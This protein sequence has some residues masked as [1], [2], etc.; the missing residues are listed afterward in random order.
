MGTVASASRGHSSVCLECRA[1]KIEINR[2][3]LAIDDLSEAQS[4]VFNFFVF[5]WD[6]ISHLY[7]CTKNH[8]NI[9]LFL[10]FWSNLQNCKYKQDIQSHRKYLSH[11]TTPSTALDRPRRLYVWWGEWCEFHENDEVFWKCY[12]FLKMFGGSDTRDSQSK[13][14]KNTKSTKNSQSENPLTTFLFFRKC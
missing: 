4:I 10:T 1:S 3:M 9:E 8:E 12:A 11:K 14:N 5:C 2:K 6:R 13:S 7:F